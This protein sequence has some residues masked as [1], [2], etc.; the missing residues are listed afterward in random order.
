MLSYSFITNGAVHALFV[1]DKV[2]L[3]CYYVSTLKRMMLLH[4]VEDTI[5]SD[6]EG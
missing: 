1:I 2:G 6:K 4:N 3:P 5:F